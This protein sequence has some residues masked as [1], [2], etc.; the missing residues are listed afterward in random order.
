M[1]NPYKEN[2]TLEF[3][4]LDNGTYVLDSVS[5][6]IEGD[7]FIPNVYNGKVVTKIG[8]YAFLGCE[9]I[10]NITFP[11]SIIEIGCCSFA[12]C[13][14][15][16]KI[17]FEGYIELIGKAAFFNCSNL[18]EV[19]FNNGVGK[20]KRDAFEQCNCIGDLKLEDDI[21]ILPDRDMFDDILN[22]VYF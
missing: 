1:L 10:T 14:A 2:R 13:F 3:K 16:R 9:K 18:V 8:D 19:N 5:K 4:L 22:D 15:L 20:I 17:E 11:S 7:V 21:Y 12:E 6:D